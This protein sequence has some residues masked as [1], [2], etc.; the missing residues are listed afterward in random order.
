MVIH[1]RFSLFPA[2]NTKPLIQDYRSQASRAE[3]MTLQHQLNLYL[4][5]AVAHSILLPSWLISHDV[6]RPNPLS[7]EGLGYYSV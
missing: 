3:Q 6:Y 1:R 4:A 7:V 2:G 5:C